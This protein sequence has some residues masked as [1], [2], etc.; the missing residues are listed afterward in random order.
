M[1]QSLKAIEL[2]RRLDDP[3]TEAMSRYFAALASWSL[4]DVAGARLHTENGLAVSGRL[5]DHL[6]LANLLWAGE[7]I[8]RL[9]GDF[10]S[11]RIFSDRGLALMPR[12]P[13]LLGTRALLEY[14]EGNFERGDVFYQKLLEEMRHTPSSASFEYAF[15]A[16]VTGFAA[17]Y[18][19][20]ADRFDF[21]AA[22]VAA[23]T[24]LSSPTVTPLIA[25][26]AQTGLALMAVEQR[27]VATAAEGYETHKSR[28]GT[29]TPGGMGSVDHLLGLLAMVMGQLDVA[30][31][32]L[33]DALSFC[34]KAGY[35]PEYA[36]AALDY[37]DV[38]F[39]QNGPAD[40]EKAIALQDESLAI[41]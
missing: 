31:Q 13:R 39:M 26:R 35:R 11:A 18:T 14:E 6:S 5:R 1:E 34:R 36:H 38:L 28:R 25:I 21:N 30:M 29:V 7:T 3:S 22:K 40:R 24:V 27:D 2:A 23:K 20:V 41:A 8:G 19:G 9:T 17:H 12:D 4:G 37:A 16:S 32:H 10:R 33:E 15:L